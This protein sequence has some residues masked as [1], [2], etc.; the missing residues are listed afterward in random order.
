MNILSLRKVV[1]RYENF[2]AVDKVSL[3]IPKGSIYGMLGPNG[4]GKTSIL[5]MITQILLPDEGQILFENEP[6]SPKHLAHIGYMPEERGLYKKMKVY[7]QLLYF[8][9]LRGYTKSQAERL[10]SVWI[11][12][13]NIK[14]WLHKKSNELS[15]GQH[16][17]LQFIVTVAHQP[18]LLILD[19]PFSGLDPISANLI[20]DEIFELHKK[21][22]T[23]IFSTHRMEQVEEICDNI[24][25]IH[26][27]KVL[28]E[29]SLSQI[30]QRFR[31]PLYQ[32]RLENS[33]ISLTDLDPIKIIEKFPN[34]TVIECK[35]FDNDR[36]VLEY[37]VQHLPI[38]YFAPLE[39]PLNDIFIEVVSQR[40]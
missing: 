30:K 22:V 40:N 27:G 19:E 29:G 35:G 9:Q 16:Q 33:E 37:L 17:K 34:Y 10:L 21:G 39:T 13:L 12:K 3:N 24:C 18:S 14:D 7:E 23:V 28:L 31:K 11:E 32:I 38:T 6:L 26:Q 15:K 5:R 20:K 36:K 1:K 2:I 4:A 8:V 25:L